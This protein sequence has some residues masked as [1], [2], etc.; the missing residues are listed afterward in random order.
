[1]A[2]AMVLE[3]VR[4]RV[5]VYFTYTCHVYRDVLCRGMGVEVGLGYGIGLGDRRF[6]VDVLGLPLMSSTRTL[7]DVP[8]GVA[9]GHSGSSVSVAVV[10]SCNLLREKR[11]VEEPPQ[12]SIMPTGD[13]SPRCALRTRI[14]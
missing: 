9:R 3:Y 10:C 5:Q 2:L 12:V 1:M 8:Q 14:L 6:L 11:R 4:T 7:W 13:Y